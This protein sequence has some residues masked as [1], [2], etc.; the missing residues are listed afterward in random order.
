MVSRP[1]LIGRSAGHRRRIGLFGGSFNPPHEGHR[2][3]SLLALKRL[4]LDE[5]W[6]LVSPANPLKESGEFAP[7][8]ERC[9]AA[10]SV[11][12]HPRIRISTFERDAGLIYTRDTLRALT[13]SRKDVR[14]VWLMGADNLVSIHLWSHWPEIF[15]LVP[16]AV[17]DRPSYR[18]RAM[19]SPAAL[20]YA[21][22]RIDEDDARLLAGLAP[23]VWCFLSGPLNVLSSS[24]LRHQKTSRK[25]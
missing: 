17:I 20:R 23:P 4:A 21:D 12:R 16:V 19:S 3:A 6:W 24:H 14:F 10:R 7:Y 5:V 11:A 25:N 13:R 9:A 15:E 2:H 22:R 1:S 18:L 8:E